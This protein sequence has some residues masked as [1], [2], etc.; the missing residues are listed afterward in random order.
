MHLN[1]LIAYFNNPKPN[2]FNSYM[3]SC[4]CHNDKKQS[5]CISEKE[6][7]IL[8]NC[9]A[10]CQTDDILNAVGLEQK[11]L[12]NNINNNTALSKKPPN[13]DYYYNNNLKKNRFYRLYNG[14]WEKNFCWKH[15][16]NGKWV[17]GAGCKNIPL[18]KEYQLKSNFAK[19]E[20]VYIVEGEKDVD[21]LTRLGLKAVCSPHGASLNNLENKWRNEYNDRFN[22][23]YVVIIPDNDDVGKAFAYLI[24]N[25]LV[26]HANSIKV[27]NLTDEWENLPQKG[28]ITDALSITEPGLGNNRDEMF[29]AKLDALTL[30][31][32]EFKP[33]EADYNN[34]VWEDPIPFDIIELP[35]FPIDYMP[36]SIQPYLRALAESIQVPIDMVCCTALGLISLCNQDKYI[37]KVKNGWYEQINLYMLIIAAPSERKSPALSAQLKILNN[38]EMNYNNFYKLEFARTRTELKLLK[39]KRENLINKI[40][41]GKSKDYDTD[42]QEL[43][44]LDEE[45]ATFKQKKELKL[46][47][48]NITP[49]ELGNVMVNEEGCSAIVSAEGGIFDMLAGGMYSKNVNI[50]IFLKAFS[51]DDFRVDRVSRDSVIIRNPTLTM[52]LFVQPNVIENMMSN[53][54][55]KGRGLTSRFLYSM[56]KSLVGHR[57]F[58]TASVPESEKLKFE[59]LIKDLLDKDK[60]TENNERVTITLNS[61]ARTVFEKYYLFVE[62]RLNG[63]F[64][65]IAEW[66]GKIA[67]TTARIAALL[68][69]ADNTNASDYVIDGETM[70]RAVAI[71]KYFIEHFLAVYS[72][73]GAD[74]VTNLS[75]YVVER[76]KDK[77]LTVFT[78]REISRECK[79]IKTTDQRDDVLNN[80]I[81]LGYIKELPHNNQEKN[82]GR[83][84]GPK[85]IAHPCL[86]EDSGAEVDSKS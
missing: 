24:A 9:F 13:V 82:A 21:T 67:G 74:T 42:Q 61:E 58:N 66:A 16:K 62:K 2:G 49:E 11:N 12:F 4:P 28:D 34:I 27:L 50:D 39:G 15:L 59:A 37:V 29:L 64:E 48:D 53:R 14:K 30:T 10:G 79:K 40:T 17:N 26:G 8:I 19:D 6:G 78:P 56:P 68:W 22:G 20:A 47:H 35:V 3:V 25:N 51:G 5:L 43:S 55:F 70:K 60:P 69:C 76:I 23:L 52:L 71:G 77:Q 36:V 54:K 46:Y 38:Y 44:Y 45:I 72:F 84:S 81:E 65:H 85:Y 33:P 18:Y 31:T 63:D 41:K 1:G 7:K 86:F 32:T 75:K 73:M 57:P 83:P 80:L